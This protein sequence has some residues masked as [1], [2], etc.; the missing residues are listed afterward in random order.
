MNQKQLDHFVRK[1]A[2][3]LDDIELLINARKTKLPNPKTPFK[4]QIRVS[5]FGVHNIDAP[6]SYFAYGAGNL[7]TSPLWLRK[8]GYN[9]FAKATKKRY[10][11]QRR[12]GFTNVLGEPR[13]HKTIKKT[14]IIQKGNNTTR[15]FKQEN[16][17]RLEY[18]A[19]Y[20]NLEINFL[21]NGNYK[22]IPPKEFK[23]F[24]RES[25]MFNF[26]SI[27]VSSKDDLKKQITELGF[28]I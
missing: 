4:S 13:T 16:L 14:T 8:S 19:A 12:R 11:K 27:E 23:K 24:D 22:I 17:G 6:V 3:K 10:V 7:L 20:V 26:E 18:S 5:V 1:R 25:S 21:T 15:E 2:I 9:Q 28:E